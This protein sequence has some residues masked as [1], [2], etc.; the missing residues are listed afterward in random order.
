MNRSHDADDIDSSADRHYKTISTPTTNYFEGPL[1]SKRERKTRRYERVFSYDIPLYIP[2]VRC[3]NRS[4]L[5]LPLSDLNASL[6]A[7]D[8]I[9]RR[10]VCLAAGSISLLC[11]LYT[12]FSNECTK[13]TFLAARLPGFARTES[14]RKVP[15]RYAIAYTTT[16]I[17]VWNCIVSAQRN[18][19][20]S[21]AP[22]CVFFKRFGDSRA[23]SR[24]YTTPD[25]CPVGGR[26]LANTL[27]R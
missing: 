25:Q 17:S 21:T 19:I 3:V 11:Q 10:K 18:S 5:Y 1:Q 26:R 14:A 12:N 7:Q 16:T 22:C 24:L 15:E 4:V 8:I 23:R 27:L 6:S 2:I 9:V 13:S 20:N